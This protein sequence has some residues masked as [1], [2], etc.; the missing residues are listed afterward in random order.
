M[1]Y[2]FTFYIHGPTHTNT[3]TNTQTHIHT[4]GVTSSQK[5]GERHFENFFLE[6]LRPAKL[7][8]SFIFKLQPNILKKGKFRE[9]CCLWFCLW[10]C[11]SGVFHQEGVELGPSVRPSYRLTV[12]HPPVPPQKR[13]KIFTKAMLQV[14]PTNL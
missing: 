4:M 7:L 8:A 6:A 13:K 5:V 2:V 10:V 3:H 11:L 12:R 1:I 14:I 9:P